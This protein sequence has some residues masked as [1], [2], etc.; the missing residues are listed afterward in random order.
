[1]KVS[2][3]KGEGEDLHQLSNS[4]VTSYAGERDER[5]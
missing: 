3:H 5:T 1:M 2:P 4:N